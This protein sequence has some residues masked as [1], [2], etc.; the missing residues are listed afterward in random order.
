MRILQVVHGFPPNNLAGTEVYTYNLS[1]ELAKRHNVFVFHRINDLNM[2]EHTV[3]HSKLNGVDTFTINNTFR[4]YDSFEATY[5]NQIIAEK[6]GSILDEVKPNIV[7]IQHLM[8]LG[9]E[10]IEEIQKRRIPIVFTLHDY[11]LFCPQ[12]QLLENSWKRCENKGKETKCVQCILYQLSIKK[13]IFFAYYFLKRYFPD[14]LFQVFKDIYLSY[15]K[16]TS[17]SETKVEG[18]I[19]ERAAYI[20]DI[21]SKVNLFIAPSQFLREKFLRF[22]IHENR[23]IFIPYGFNIDFF[24]NLNKIKSPRL[25]FGFI[26]NIMPAKGV[27]ILIQCFNKI[28]NNNAELKIYGQASS[29]KSIRENYLKYIKK[30]A[31]NKNIKFMGGFDN[32]KIA[33]IFAEIDILVVPSIWH[34]NSPLVIQEAFLA[35]TPVIASRIGGIPELVKDGENGLLFNPADIKELG[36]KI[37]YIINNPEVIKKFQENM[38]K[39]KSIEENAKEIE[40]I[41]TDLIIKNKA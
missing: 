13:N 20:K 1:R 39:V 24:K 31:R 4:L 32:N 37:E 14:S 11:W 2:K 23:I 8:Y 29:Y 35:K 26:G 22:G 33:E 6:F 17:L 28:R 5:K 21:C 10:I 18:L 12:G 25:R 7:H 30:I 19:K 27:H 9:A 16:S 38:P 36:E 40:E 15:C 34:E 3:I 41:Y